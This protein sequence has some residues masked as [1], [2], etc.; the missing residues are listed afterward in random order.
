MES[1]KVSTPEGT[2]D[3]F[4]A[5]CE[6]LREIRAAIVRL[7]R[8]RGYREVSTP[9]LEY[10]DLLCVLAAPCLRKACLS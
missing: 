2:R 8:G 7:F 5:E 3:R 10:Y 1:Y 6:E 9:S 4:F